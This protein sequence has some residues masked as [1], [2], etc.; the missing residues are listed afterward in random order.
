M[1]VLS[2]LELVDQWRSGNRDAFATVVEKYQNLVCSVAYAKTGS[3]AVSEE[4]AQDAFLNAWRSIGELRDPTRLR[5]WLCGI[6]RN[7]ARN[8]SRRN[9]RDVM[10]AAESIEHSVVVDESETDPQEQSMAREETDLLDRTMQGLP[11]TYREP[12][13]LFYREQ[14]SVARVAELLDLSPDAVK[15][16]LTRGRK[17][18]REEIVAVVERGLSSSAPGVAFTAGVMAAVSTMTGTAKAATATITA[19]KGASAMKTAGL[20]GMAGAIGGPL[21]GVLG[22]WLGYRISVKQA[23]TDEE[24]TFLRRQMNYTIATIVLFS[25]AILSLLLLRSQYQNSPWFAPAIVGVVGAFMVAAIGGTGWSM[26][27]LR[28]IHAKRSPADADAARQ[29]LPAWL[30]RFYRPRRWQSKLQLLGVPLVSVNFSSAS[31]RKDGRA[32]AYGWIAIGDMAFGWLLA[33][34]SI[35]VAPVAIGAFCLGIVSAGALAIGIAS[36]GGGAIGWLALGGMAVG[37]MASGGIA[38]AWKCATGGM[39]VAREYAVGGSAF[40]RH[41]ND[42]IAKAFIEQASF[43]RTAEYFLSPWTPFVLV[44]FMLVTIFVT[45]HYA[46]VADTT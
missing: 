40:A 28:R 6:V 14:Q 16:R 30:Q 27:T 31:D 39:A 10:H 34:G 4:L 1:T 11:E 42:D 8:R 7:L 46:P 12:L 33:V 45:R 5:Q 2:D 44:A 26:R 21:L 24:R 36:Y 43:L 22:A 19:A 37:W 20:M 13:V 3:V 17:L 35:A 15:Q 32:I 38:L 41:A 9:E 29:N 23:L 25:G 18:L